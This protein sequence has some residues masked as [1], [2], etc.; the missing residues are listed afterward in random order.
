MSKEQATATKET[1]NK[2]QSQLDYEGGQEFLKNGKYTEAANAF[3]NSLI[4]FQKDN[5]ENGI[6]NAS[7]KLG[8]ICLSKNNFD[9]ALF[10]WDV[11]Y[12]IVEK[13]EDRISLFS[14]E[15]KRAKLYWQWKKYEQ[16]IPLYLKIID[17][18]LLD[19]NPQG[20]VDTL[21]TLSEIH[22]ENGD[23]GKAADCLRTAASIH[24]TFKH[25]NFEKR[26]L[27]KAEE[28]ELS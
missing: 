28:I 8:D 7:D 3:H 6:A 17:E 20:V 9:Q 14:I 22:L 25:A 23:K 10:N 11:A 5:D 2:S 21:E 1:E 4:G 13:L 24:K 19:N 12:K 15:K 26:L 16:A 18:Y 27:E